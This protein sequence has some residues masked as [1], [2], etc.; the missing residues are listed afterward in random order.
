MPHENGYYTIC[1]DNTKL[2]PSLI[3]T[4]LLQKGYKIEDFNVCEQTL[5]DIVKE[6]YNSANRKKFMS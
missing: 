4:E 1:F 5:E 6:I 3:L 2:S